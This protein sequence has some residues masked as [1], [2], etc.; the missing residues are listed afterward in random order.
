M[1]GT[2]PWLSSGNIQIPRWKG[3]LALGS[4][5]ALNSGSAE[6]LGR[7]LASL[8]PS[9]PRWGRWRKVIASRRGVKDHVTW[10]QSL[11]LASWGPQECN[12]SE[13]EEGQETIAFD[14]VVGAQ[15]PE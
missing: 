10:G 6:W 8:G 13:T 11:A 9:C 12:R 5:Q 14:L 1:H 7:P 3:R 2:Q 15:D 4:E